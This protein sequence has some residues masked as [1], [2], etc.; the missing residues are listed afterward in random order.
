MSSKRVLII[1][2][3]LGGRCLAQGLKRA[4]I[5]FSLFERGDGIEPRGRGYCLRINAAGQDALARCLPVD[6]LYLLYQSAS[7][8]DAE[9][10]CIDGQLGPAQIAT[11]RSLAP[12]G[13]LPDLVVHRQT[14]W[15]ILQCGLTSNLHLEH[16]LDGYNETEDSVVARFAGGREAEGHL[17]VGA[18]GVHSAVRGQLL[19][20]LA[21]EDMGHACI[22]GRMSAS[23]ANCQA[24]GRDLCAGPSIIQADGFTATVEVMTF[25]EPMSALAARI[26][27]DCRLTPVEDYVHWALAGSNERLGLARSSWDTGDIVWHLVR[28]WAPALQALFLRGDPEEWM[29]QPIQTLPPGQTWD[30]QRVTLIGDAAHVP[31]SAGGL[32]AGIALQDAAELAAGLARAGASS[33][34]TPVLRR[35]EAEMRMRGTA[36]E[37]AP[38]AVSENPSEALAA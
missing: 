12:S 9:P 38:L 1:G 25:R 32:D 5:P 3:G 33:D 29:I 10:W 6:L 24:I 36:A 11:P 18:D 35:Y 7:L 31:G 20:N 37:D 23:P 8:A 30:S 27:P 13:S 26:A 4:G 17:L 2:G 34:L 22:Y 14:L 16:S 28:R 15:E 21:P 19:P